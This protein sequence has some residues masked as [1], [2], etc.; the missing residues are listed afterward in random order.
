ML[1]WNCSSDW[2]PEWVE[3]TYDQEEQYGRNRRSQSFVACW[4]KDQEHLDAGDRHSR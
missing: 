1:V 3:H 4:K 2:H